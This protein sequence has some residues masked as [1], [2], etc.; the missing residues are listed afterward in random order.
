[1]PDEEE[2]V[3]EDEEDA[4]VDSAD[5][6]GEDGFL[7]CVS[8]RVYVCACVCVCDERGM[9]ARELVAFLNPTLSIPGIHTHTPS[10]VCSMTSASQLHLASSSSVLL[11]FL[12]PLSFLF[13]LL[14]SFSSMT[15]GR[16]AQLLDPK[17]VRA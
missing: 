6:E 4:G 9:G 17:L 8:V 13:R 14:F 7:G 16:A 12:A 10:L 3:E 11:P 1:M 2:D 15:N 5:P